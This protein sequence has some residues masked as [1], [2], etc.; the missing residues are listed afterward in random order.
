MREFKD[1]STEAN[2]ATGSLRSVASAQ[3]RLN[4]T[5]NRGLSAVHTQNKLYQAQRGILNGLP[6]FVNSYVSILGAYRL[7]QNIVDTTAEFEMQRVALAAIIQNKAKADELFSQN[8]ELGLKSPFQIKDLITYTK[9]LA[10]YKIETDDLFDTTKRLADVSA[11]LGVGMDRLV[12]AYGQVRAASVLRGQELRQFTEAGIPLVSLL[13]DKFTKLNGEATSTGDVFK[14]ISQRAVSFNM[15][16]E[17][18]D[19][20]TNAGGTFY[21]M[22]EIQSQT[23]KGSLSNIKDAY[24]KMFMQIGNSEMGPMKDAVDAIK[25]L[26]DNWEAISKI[27]T[28][29]AVSFGIVKV[30]MLANNAVLRRENAEN[31][32]SIITSKK[33]EAILLRQAAV[34][35]AL[36]DTELEKI[37]TS[38]MMTAADWKQLIV[39]GRLKDESILRMVALKK[40]TPEMAKELI[41][42]EAA[43]KAKIGLTVADIENASTMKRSVVVR[44]MAIASIKAYTAALWAS[45]KVVLM[46]P[47]T[48]AVVAIAA[49]VKLTSHIIKYNREYSD[50]SNNIRKDSALLANEMTE[51]YSRMKDVVQKGLAP[52]ATEQSIISARKSLQDIIEKNQFIKDIIDER[53]KSVDSEAERLEVI[54][55]MWN[56]IQVA[57]AG[58]NGDMAFSQKTTGSLMNDDV[59][60]NAEDLAKRLTAIDKYL[61]D[62]GARGYQ[63][64]GIRDAFKKLKEDFNLGTI[65]LDEFQEKLQWIYK[66]PGAPKSAEFVGDLVNKLG[67]ASAEARKLNEDF[68]KFKDDYI[69]RIQEINGQKIDKYADKL[70]LS[71]ANFNEFQTKLAV[72]TDAWIKSL[73]DI[74]IAA[75]QLLIT[76]TKLSFQFPF[77]NEETPVEPSAFERNYNAYIAKMGYGDKFKVAPS[78]EG[79]PPKEGDIKKDLKDKREANKDRLAELDNLLKNTKNKDKAY[80]AELRKSRKDT[81]T[82]LTEI[83]NLWSNFFGGQ[84]KNRKQTDPRISALKA[85]LDLVN[86]AYQEYLKLSEYL[87]KDAAKTK[88]TAQYGGQNKPISGVTNTGLPLAFTQVE[89]DS[90]YAA[91][92]SGFEK[93]GKDAVDEGRNAFKKQADNAFDEIKRN[94][95]EEFR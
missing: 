65:T 26:M 7:G 86:E 66:V 70:G 1:L 41:V 36:K 85:Q 76:N 20:M 54:R 9:Q 47:M 16:K 37:K 64:V 92:I 81:A 87:G 30:A 27:I 88:V 19:D 49:I 39:E 38:T 46:N 10:A 82:E 68:N 23:L 52:G 33:K 72:V 22:Q 80:L 58:D 59:V 50:M 18:F 83:E 4:N 73:G 11:G 3:E 8:V 56:Q 57:A 15:V 53:L 43:T 63:T 34:Y 45:M 55:N 28:A 69:S 95:Q 29:G 78:E 90:A 5:T 91:G 25:E 35:R 32:T 13:A 6:Q 67:F 61:S 21:R 12:L 75:K 44:R 14:L 2:K 31:I 62:M 84:D 48:W 74:D 77:K 60:E 51:A 71:D 93:L 17:V 42:T 94:I 79:A 89:L 24:Q 40:M